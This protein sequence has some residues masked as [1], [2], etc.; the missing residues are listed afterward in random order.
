MQKIVNELTQKYD[1]GIVFK[2]T[3]ILLKKQLN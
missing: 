3:P 2:P 1:M